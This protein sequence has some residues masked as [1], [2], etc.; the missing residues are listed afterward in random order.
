MSNEV[1]PTIRKFSS[2]AQRNAAAGKG[3][4]DLIPPRALHAVAQVYEKGALKHGENNWAKGM[5]TKYMLDSA[6]RHIN[7][8]RMGDQGDPHLSHAI[9]NLLCALENDL[10]PELKAIQA[11]LAGNKAA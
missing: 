8:Y 3:R 7:Q 9:W 5:P 6:L 4:Y 10:D 2:G 1:D 11:G